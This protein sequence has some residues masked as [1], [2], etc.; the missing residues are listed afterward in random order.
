MAHLET[1]DLE[2]DAA[3]KQ[4]L[5]AFLL[6]AADDELVMGHRESEWLGMAPEIEEDIA[7]GSISQDEVGHAVF[8]YG[9]LA[10]L[11][12]ERVESL[13]Y[14]RSASARR[15]AA[16]L[17]RDNGDWAYTIVRQYF[18]DEFDH[19]RLTALRDSSYEPLRQGVV[20]ML[21]EEYYHRLHATTWFRR[22]ALAPGEAKERILRAVAAQWADLPDLFA[23][24]P[25]EGLLF[26]YGVLAMT[27]SDLVAAWRKQTA[28]QMSAAGLDVP[29]WPA[30]GESGELSPRESREQH[31]P[32][33]EHLLT[34][35]AEVYNLDRAAAW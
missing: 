12:G 8:Y 16:L 1:S 20:K 23:F 13:A 26:D 19:L 11:T 32:A 2:A 25:T 14:E 31:S 3:L 6:Q 17:E 27:S 9:L 18:Y 29:A 34:T 24:G 4:A 5:T 10:Q 21:R 22:L 28:S 15:N 7:F 30:P 33:L 35:L